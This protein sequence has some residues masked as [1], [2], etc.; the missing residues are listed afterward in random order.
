MK[1]NR[2]WQGSVL[3]VSILILLGLGAAGAE[4]GGRAAPLQAPAGT[5]FTY[6]G[7]LE[8]GGGPANGLYDIRFYLFDD[9]VAGSQVA[10]YITL[11]DVSVT[12]G[13]FTVTLDYGNVFD[14]DS[15]W[16]EIW[17]RPGA[18]TGSYQQLLPRQSL[19]P[20]PYASYA[21]HIPL[22]GSGSATTA[23]HSD[24][25][26]FGQIWIGAGGNGLTIYASSGT[27]FYG[28]AT[29]IG[30]SAIYGWANSSSGAGR[31]V[32]GSSNA[33][34][35][36]GVAGFA[37]SDLGSP[38]GVQGGVAAVSGY[39]GYFYNVGGG[40]LLVASNTADGSDLQFRVSNVGNV[41][42]DG[43]FTGG[44]ADFAELIPSDGGLEPGDVVCMGSEGALT[45]CSTV[46]DPTVVGVYSTEPA[47]LAG[48]N[49]DGSSVGTVPVAMMGLLPVKA[50]AENG[51]IQIGDPLVSASLPGHAMRCEGVETCFGRVIGKALEPLEAGTGLIQMLVMLQ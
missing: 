15:R 26:H 42:A 45:P 9:A 30:E 43:A 7:H 4:G 8:D 31:G 6:Q 3:V 32:T 51:A 48:G 34:D 38:T 10:P 1:G 5:A 16:L 19:T 44:G 17:I 47:F 18:S 28:Q 33:S 35:G 23:A 29:G 14:G 39:G 24:H 12:E 13:L 46:L 22:A 50:S 37:N 41:F 21:M 49:S 25:N 20:V 40:A 36:I 27:A 2:I 11:Q